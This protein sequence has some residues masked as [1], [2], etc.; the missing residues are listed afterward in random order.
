MEHVSFSQITQA[1]QCPYSYYLTRFAGVE[2]K[3]N[4]FAQAG[5]FVHLILYNKS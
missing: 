4:A 5:S 1:E 3:E 2:P